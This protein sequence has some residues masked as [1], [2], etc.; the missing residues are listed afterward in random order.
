[1]AGDEADGSAISSLSDLEAA[2]ARRVGPSEWAYVQGGAEE[3]RAL[4]ANRRAFEVRT[5][6]SSMVFYS[7]PRGWKPG[8]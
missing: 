2:A 3:E 7:T 1:M 8:P 6:P 4:R 5:V